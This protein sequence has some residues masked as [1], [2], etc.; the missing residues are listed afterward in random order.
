[1]TTPTYQRASGLTQAQQYALDLIVTGISDT[2]VA[3]LIG[4]ARETVTRW[5]LYDDTFRAE[6]NRRRRQVWDGALDGIRVI[7]PQAVD[8]LRA[9]PIQSPSRGRL[10]LDLIS[11]AGLL[12]KPYSG[13]LAIPETEL[14]PNDSLVLAAGP[15]DREDD[16]VA[17]PSVAEAGPRAEP[18]PD[19][20]PQPSTAHSLAE[21]AG[22]SVPLVTSR[23]K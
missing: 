8:T 20:Q 23:S 6:L 14:V 18:L 1:M 15:D 21:A 19:A 13:A 16:S 9:Q 5:R 3:N 17:R 10:A 22:E 2:Q 12:G 7:L 11:R 4:L